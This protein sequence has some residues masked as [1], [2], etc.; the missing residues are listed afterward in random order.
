MSAIPMSSNDNRYQHNC[1][2]LE[3]KQTSICMA[4]DRHN[5]IWLLLYKPLLLQE[6]TS[7]TKPNSHQGFFPIPSHQDWITIIVVQEELAL[8]I[9][10]LVNCSFYMLSR[11]ASVGAMQSSCFPLANN[12]LSTLINLVEQESLKLVRILI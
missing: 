8:T 9:P 4:A 5:S 6:E 10:Y 2:A 3:V 12:N 1:K 7:R 11:A